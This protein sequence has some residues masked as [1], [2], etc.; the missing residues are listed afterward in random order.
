[1]HKPLVGHLKIALRLLRYLKSCPGKGLLFKRGNN[2]EVSC[3]ADSDWG[4]CLQTRKSVSGY[5]V[6]LGSNLV[7]WKSKKQSTVSRSSG[8][9]EYRAMCS[10]TCE[11]IWIV[12]VLKELNVNCKVPLNLYCDSSAAISIGA[13]PVFHE[14]TKHFELDLFFLR[15]KIASG[16]IRTVKIDS[17]SQLADVFTKGLSGSQHD[18]FCERLSLVD[19]FKAVE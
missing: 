19:L 11:L 4:K 5:C 8:E 14:R 9:A 12:N 2:L 13:N 1:M 6:F 10:A 3:Y 7:S 16:F 17:E 18:V 15:E